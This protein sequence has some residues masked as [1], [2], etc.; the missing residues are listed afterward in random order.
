[1]AEYERYVIGMRYTQR[2]KMELAIKGQHPQY[3]QG[4]NAHKDE[5]P[6]DALEMLRAY[7]RI[8]QDSGE[9]LT[10]PVC[11][12]VWDSEPSQGQVLAEVAKGNVA[13]GIE[14]TVSLR[15]VVEAFLQKKA[16]F[17]DLRRAIGLQP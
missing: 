14:H 2:F 4:F 11:T 7:S 5:I 12:T 9:N 15:P 17:A 1:M 3:Y 16:T 8:L 6:Q 13:A 10:T